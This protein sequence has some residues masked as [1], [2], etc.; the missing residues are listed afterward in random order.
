MTFAVLQQRLFQQSEP[1]ASFVYTTFAVF[2]RKWR[3]ADIMNFQTFETLTLAM[4]RRADLGTGG[5]KGA[6]GHARPPNCR[7]SQYVP[8]LV[9]WRL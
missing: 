8:G 7:P 6:G 4:V 9:F 5:F 1:E 3:P 2:T